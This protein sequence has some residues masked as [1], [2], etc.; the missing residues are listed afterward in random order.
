MKRIIENR[1]WMLLAAVVVST[2]LFTFGSEEPGSDSLVATH[3]DAS[4]PDVN[5]PAKPTVAA[6][7]SAGGEK[8]NRITNAADEPG[9][10]RGEDVLAQHVSTFHQTDYLSGDLDERQ[11]EAFHHVN[12]VCDGIPRNEQEYQEWYVRHASDPHVDT[13]YMREQMNGCKEVELASLQEQQEVYR[14]V[15]KTEPGNPHAAFYLSTSF[16]AGH[17]DRMRLLE[18][19][20][21]Q[22]FA[23][24]ATLLAKEH[25]QVE[26]QK[27]LPSAWA[28]MKLAE[29]LGDS[30]AAFWVA[31]LEDRMQSGE[32]AMAH[33]VYD[34]L[35]SGTGSMN[36][37]GQ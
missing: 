37:V 10:Q 17:P 9:L 7:T 19:S 27:D 13:D 32:I 35:T 6:T 4:A 22:G 15:L 23:Q 1:Y 34:K 3:V 24:A 28:W 29:T 18:E 36:R 20:A 12:L 11:L 31:E 2:L 14:R 5:G 16:P 8:E 33:R 30:E 21:A 26:N 25:F